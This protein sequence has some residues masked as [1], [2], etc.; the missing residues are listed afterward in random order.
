MSTVASAMPQFEIVKHVTLPQLK[1]EANQEYFVRFEGAIHEADAVAPT[2]NRK[3]KEGEPA[4]K[5]GGQFD[6]P[7]ELAEVTNL[8]TGVRCQIIVYAVLSE[9]L[10][11]KYTGDSYIGKS[12]RLA[13]TNLQ[14]K[15][16]KGWEVAEVRL[17]TD[18]K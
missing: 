11:K 6:T 5:A 10:R 15:R 13:M 1:F 17:K 12:F 2:R 16:Y 9:E 4:P 3:A 8:V 14:G 7:P 18:K